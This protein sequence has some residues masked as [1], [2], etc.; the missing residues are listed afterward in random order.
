[1]TVSPDSPEFLELFERHGPRTGAELVELTR[2]EPLPLWRRCHQGDLR[3]ERV[4][5]RYL[6]L[7]RVVEGYARLS[8]SI[9]REFL[10]YTVIGLP[11]QREQIAART[12]KLT[13]EAELVSRAK[14]NEAREAMVSVVAELGLQADLAEDVTFLIAG[15]V[16]YGMAH[17]VPR[18]EPS[19]GQMVR[20]SDLDIIIVTT[21]DYPPDKL[22]A[23]DA[24]IH[25]KKHRLLVHPSHREEIDYIIKR[26]RTVREQLTFATF[27]HQVASKILYEGQ[28]LC[29]SRSLYETIKGLVEESGV[30]SQLADGEGRAIIDRREAEAFLLA[31]SDDRQTGLHYN[32]FYTHAEDD[33]IY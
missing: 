5:H 23:L 17:T 24:A 30:P 9:R 12:D 14:S 21:D 26:M 20:G 29:G 11:S 4:G 8:P 3:L 2:A 6:R 19:T 28:L 7:D 1:M 10:T 33:E 27:E 15:D 16:V 31:S 18:P 13:D 25:R 22:K 32:L